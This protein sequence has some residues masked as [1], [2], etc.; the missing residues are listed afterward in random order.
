VKARNKYETHDETRINYGKRKSF[1][2]FK[3]LQLKFE[4]LKVSESIQ[5]I[6]YVSYD[7]NQRDHR[8]RAWKK[9]HVERNCVD[10][11]E[12]LHEPNKNNHVNYTK[13][14]FSLISHCF[15]LR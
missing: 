5:R 9:K 6:A 3:Q 10:V 1:R 4:L 8:Q 15:I 14:S 2:V 7:E 11:D 13:R 12:D